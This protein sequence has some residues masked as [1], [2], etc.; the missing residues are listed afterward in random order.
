MNRLVT[1][2]L[3]LFSL[4][5]AASEAQIRNVV[6]NAESEEGKL[7]QQAGEES[8]SAKKIAVLEQFLSK[9]GSHEAAGF[10][11]LQLQAEYLKT[12]V[13][14]KS[15][16]HGEKAQAKAPEDLEIAH[17]TVKGAEGKGDAQQLIAM[18]E[19][20]H[21]LAQKAK[22]A[23]KPTDSDEAE[24]WKR[25]VDF[26]SQVDDYNQYA[27]YGSAQK[28][29]TPQGKILLLDALR[30]QY[31]GS[32]FDKMLDA[33]YVVAYQQLG[34]NDKMA[35]A[36][37]AA[38]ASDPTNEAYLYMV[39]ESYM[40]PAKGKVAEAQA[41]AQKILDTLP[42]KPKPANISD[43]DWTKH[44]NTYIGLAHSLMGRSLATEGKFA[45]AQ[46]EL[47]AAAAS[48]KSNNEALSQVL[49]FLG[50]CSI[51][52]ELRRDAVKYLTEASKVPGP[53]QSEAAATLK[54]LRAAMAAK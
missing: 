23:P 18:V 5:A 7:L 12:N 10:V 30:K 4:V 8:D 33:Q 28:Q 20:T 31:P 37:E 3:C 51:K 9:F 16:E 17:L 50:Y 39:G 19:K 42:A 29:A 43:D 36:A 26:A 48:L 35:Q 45:P 54:K 53:W 13:F 2:A 34:Q 44:K 38:L 21:A 11:H 1:T 41:S 6:I 25:K 47:L 32:Q 40:D 14:D 15:L 52:L 27:L 22:A 24:E 46:K 49:F